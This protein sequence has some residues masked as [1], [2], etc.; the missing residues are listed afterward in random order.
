MLL[1]VVSTTGFAGAAALTTALAVLGGPFGM[2]GG[3]A[4]LGV[5]GLISKGVSDYGFGRI[6]SKS[7]SGLKDKGH[8]EQ[9]VIDKINSLPI[10]K[11]LKLKLIDKI[12]NP[13][14][15][16]LFSLDGYNYSKKDS[17]EYSPVFLRKN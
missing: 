14:D 2:V 7:M 16:K 13:K 4:L 17:S 6:Y 3:I 5:L 10:S 1:V 11:S 15:L 12:K 9:E 8:S